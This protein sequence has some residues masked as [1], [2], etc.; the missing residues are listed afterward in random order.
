MDYSHI[1]NL[2]LKAR[3]GVEGPGALVLDG[4]LIHTL[5]GNTDSMDELLI[6]QVSRAKLKSAM[7]CLSREEQEL[8]KYVYFDGKSLKSYF[9]IKEIS[10]STSVSRKASVLKRLRIYIDTPHDRNYLN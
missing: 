5:C 10:Y 8:I 4:C 9:A 1:K 2:V 7:K 6:K 3:G